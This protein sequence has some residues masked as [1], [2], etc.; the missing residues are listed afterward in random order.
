MSGA[1][2][3]GL[4]LKLVISLGVVLGLMFGLTALLRRRGMAGF[5]SNKTRRALTGVDVEVLARKPLGRNASIAIVRAGTKSMVL[6]VTDSMVTMLTEAE[7]QELEL[8]EAEAQGT[9]FQRAFTGASPTWKT[10][11]EG[12]R[13]KTVRRT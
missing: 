10:M 9:G 2:T 6:G 8:D 12:L 13:D 5:A 7:V 3:F 4:L 11:L 1:S